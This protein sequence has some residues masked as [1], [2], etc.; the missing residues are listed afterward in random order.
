MVEKLVAKG[1]RPDEIAVFSNMALDPMAQRPDDVLRKV[2]K[3]TGQVSKED[4]AELMR[5]GKIR[6]AIG[7]TQTMGTGVNAQTHMR[8]MHHLDAPWTPGEFEQRNGRGHRQGNEWNTVFEYRYYT[9]GSH[10][11]RRWQVLLNKVKF[12]SRFTE[13]LLNSGG[14]DLRVLTGDGANLEEEGSSVADFEQSLS[15]AAGDPRIMIRAK[16]KSDVDKLERKMDAHFQAIARAKSDI[17]DLESKKISQGARVEALARVV[18]AVAKVRELPFSVTIDGKVFTER[19]EAE[20]ALAAY[21]SLTQSD[22]RKVVVDYH[23][24]KVVHEW[25]KNSSNPSEFYA[26][27][28]TVGNATEEIP[29]GNLSI[30]SLESNLRVQ[31]RN[32]ANLKESYDTIDASIASLEDMAKRPFTRTDELNAKRKSLQQI[33]VEINRAPNAPP[34]WLRNGAPVGSLVY[35][36]DGKPYDVAAHRW[37]NNGWWILVDTD[38]GMKP[39]DYREVFDESAHPVFEETPFIKPQASKE[40]AYGMRARPFSIGAQPAGHSWIDEEDNRARYGVVYYPKPLTQDQIL[41][42]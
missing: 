38:K 23:G 36:K 1:V 26:K 9:E 37:D 16:L 2:N 35:L 3:V 4:L 18:A 29:M 13:M 42:V 11:V 8:A 12:I 19:A 39:V 22:N 41:L 25:N 32:L 5:K 34:A 40:Y 24:I 21:P 6:F 31:A 15:T 20:K 33:E 7:S 17:R 14:S 30:A 27:I 10:D 28:P